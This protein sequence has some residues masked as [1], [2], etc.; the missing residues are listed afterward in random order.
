MQ[1]QRKIRGSAEKPAGLS[2]ELDSELKGILRT[3][4]HK[5]VFAQKGLNGPV[6]LL[7]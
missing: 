6:G 3:T 1:T 7:W 2:R 5:S 4:T